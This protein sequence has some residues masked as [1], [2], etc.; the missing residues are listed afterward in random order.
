M[1]RTHLAIQATV[2]VAMV[3]LISWPQFRP[4]HAQTVWRYSPDAVA[5]AQANDAQRFSSETP[6]TTRPFH[7]GTAAYIGT[8]APLEK[9]AARPDIVRTEPFVPPAGV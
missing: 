7:L 5:E 9:A 8:N 4:V 6:D 1:R 2:V 3:A